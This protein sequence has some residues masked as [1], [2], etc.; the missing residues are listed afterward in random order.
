MVVEKYSKM[1]LTVS[2]DKLVAISGVAKHL[3]ARVEYLSD[4][5]DCY[6]AGLWR[7][8]IMSQLLWLMIALDVTSS[9]G[10]SF[11][12]TSSST[13]PSSYR[14]PSWSWAA[15]DAAVVFSRESSKLNQIATFRSATVVPAAED[16][17]G[18]LIAAT[19]VLRGT[20]Q[21]I[22]IECIEK[23]AG[24]LYYSPIDYQITTNH[25]TVEAISYSPDDSTEDVAG[26]SL[27][28][29]PVGVIDQPW[30]GRKLCRVEGLALRMAEREGEFR[31]IGLIKQKASPSIQDNDLSVYT[32]FDPT[33]IIQDVVIV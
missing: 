22:C 1:D 25:G 26:R 31:R 30:G 15:L 8:E 7:T 5:N 33:T 12:C 32:C 13:R 21:Q 28:Y 4:P 20:V 6:L 18:Q 17:T 29:L 19:L 23:T 11:Y 9:T 27:Y 2:A 10:S 16:I 14:A 24:G 3:M